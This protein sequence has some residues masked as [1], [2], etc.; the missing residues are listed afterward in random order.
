MWRSS[1]AERSRSDHSR[2]ERLSQ[3]PWKFSVLHGG[4]L[5]GAAPPLTVFAGGIAS[6]CFKPFRRSVSAGNFHKKFPPCCP[7]AVFLP[8]EP[9]FLF[10][11]H[12]RLGTIRARHH[13]IRLRIDS[14]PQ[15]RETAD[16]STGN[17]TIRTHSCRVHPIFPEIS[18]ALLLSIRALGIVF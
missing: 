3:T 6:P 16:L 10:G 1:L 4:I 2:Q 17:P 12:L 15:S 14:R 5:R 7:T 9:I 11:C 13:K 18:D 8:D